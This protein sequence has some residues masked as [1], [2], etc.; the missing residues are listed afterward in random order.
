MGSGPPDCQC[1]QPSGQGAPPVPGGRHRPPAP[2]CSRS[3][4]HGPTAATFDGHGARQ[5][6][7]RRAAARDGREILQL[8]VWVGVASSPSGP[9]AAGR[10]ARAWGWG[11]GPRGCGAITNYRRGSWDLGVGPGPG[12]QAPGGA[13]AR[14]PGPGARLNPCFCVASC[15]VA[16]CQTFGS[17]EL[18]FPSLGRSR[19]L[20]G[21]LP[22]VFW[23]LSA[24][25]AGSCLLRGPARG[26]RRARQGRPR[27]L[28][29]QAPWP[30][31]IGPGPGAFGE[32]HRGS[33]HQAPDIS[34]RPPCP[35]PMAPAHQ[36]RI[37]LRWI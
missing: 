20:S 17:A 21:L 2:A 19:G 5:A 36:P 4:G 16:V 6:R 35:W 1:Q 22:F 24:A 10:G 18:C 27:F 23:T 30:R 11:P 34:A 28:E 33:G 29:P 15:A 37:R 26:P 7:S 31:D 12:P 25:Q 13:E 9:R 8:K 32:R 3:V 14:G